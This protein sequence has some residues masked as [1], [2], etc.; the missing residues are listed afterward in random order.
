M[1]PTN[2][3]LFLERQ[4]RKFHDPRYLQLDPLICLRGFSSHNDLEIAGLVASALA[5]GRV[6]II[7]RNITAVFKLTGCDIAKFSTRTTLREKREVFKNFKHRFTDGYAIALLLQSAGAV[8]ARYGSLESLFMEGWDPADATIKKAL[9]HFAAAIKRHALRL[10]PEQRKSIEYLLPSPVSGSACK[11]LNMYLRWMVR[12][13]DGIDLGVWK[14]IP[15]CKL[16]I[17]VDTHVARVSRSLGLTRRATV[18]WQMAD[19]MTSRLR[20]ID[21]LD[22]VRFDFSLCRGGMVHFRRKAA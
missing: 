10:A 8:Q 13:N 4:F 16:V 15:A 1:T 20:A 5:Y 12:P 6:E 22:P 3:K 17:P 7:I 19:E 14:N 11:R 18:N 21:P 9:D 2:L